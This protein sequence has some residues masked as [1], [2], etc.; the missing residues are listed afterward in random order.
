MTVTANH[1]W[2]IAV[3]DPPWDH[4]Q[5]GKRRVRPNQEGSFN[6][7]TLPIGEIFRLLD[8]HVF[9]CATSPHCVFLWTVERYLT[10]SET[11]MENRGYKRHARL[12]W[13]KGNGIAPAFSIRFVHEYLIWFYKPRF[14]AISKA[15]RGVFPSIITERSREHSRKPDLSYAIIR[16]MYP[17][18][19]CLDVFSREER[20]GWSTWGDETEYYQSSHRTGE[21]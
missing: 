20:P 6:Y 17:D 14:P 15:Y 5:G 7:K 13:D 9:P 3:I 4:K 8:E 10:S 21:A 1:E 11:F 19:R 16:A 2:D 18:A 12:V